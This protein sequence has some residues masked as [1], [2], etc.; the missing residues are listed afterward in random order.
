MMITNKGFACKSAC[1]VVYAVIQ[2]HAVLVIPS[3]EYM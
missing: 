2:R 1:N 3:K